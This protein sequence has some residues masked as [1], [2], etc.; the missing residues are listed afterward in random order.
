MTRGRPASARWPEG[1]RDR[2]GKD[3]L[4]CCGH[5]AAYT[6]RFSNKCP[7]IKEHSHFNTLNHLSRASAASIPADLTGLQPPPERLTAPPELPRLPKLPEFPTVTGS[8]D[9]APVL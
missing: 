7:E 1:L 5:L 3:F 6:A 8:L 2:A 9:G 4:W